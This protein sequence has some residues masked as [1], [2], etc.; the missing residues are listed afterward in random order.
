METKAVKAQTNSNM[1]VQS[2]EKSSSRFFL[3]D[4]MVEVLL[5]VLALFPQYVSV[6]II[7]LVVFFIALTWRL[8]MSPEIVIKGLYPLFAIIPNILGICACEF[9]NI[10][11][12]ELGI[13]SGFIGSIPL[14]LVAWW[15]F[16]IAFCFV[17]NR[18]YVAFPVPEKILDSENSTRTVSLVINVINILLT[19]AFL[20]LIIHVF[21]YF[22]VTEGVDRYQ[23]TQYLQGGWARLSAYTSYAYPVIALGF[24]IANKKISLAALITCIVY[25]IWTGTKFGSFIVLITIFLFVYYP[26]LITKIK[27]GM[28]MNVILSLLSVALLVA[29]FAVVQMSITNGFKTIEQSYNYVTQRVAQQGQLW[30]RTYGLYSGSNHSDSIDHEFEVWFSGKSDSELNRDYGIYKIMR[31]TAPDSIVNQKFAQGV[32]YSSCGSAAAYYYGGIAGLLLFN[33]IMGLSIGLSTVMILS[34]FSNGWLLESLISFR[35]FQ[36]LLTGLSM[37]LFN[38][39]FSPIYILCWIVLAMMFLIRYRA[40]LRTNGYRSIQKNKLE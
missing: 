4:F 14:A 6:S 1:H 40:H 22:A 31:L 12:N 37:F 39:L 17:A 10:Y 28:A 38:E 19:V 7:S 35:L 18:K 25:L 8:V 15:T 26:K 36:L 33:I 20:I 32:R 21:P 9:Q 23:Y 16:F 5:I 29:V 3:V 30:W 11:L 27:N 13:I 2:R 34:A 24:V